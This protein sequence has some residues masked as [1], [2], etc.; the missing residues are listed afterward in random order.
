MTPAYHDQEHH[1]EICHCGRR[2][3]KHVDYD[4]GCGNVC[5]IHANVIKRRK[6]GPMAVYSEANPI[7]EGNTHRS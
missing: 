7:I 5:G 2:A 6:R 1:K 4:T 3:T